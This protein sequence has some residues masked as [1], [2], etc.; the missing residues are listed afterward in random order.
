MRRGTRSC[1]RVLGWH[2]RPPCCGRSAFAVALSYAVRDEA[3]GVEY[4]EEVAQEC[5]DLERLARGIVCDG[6]CDY[7][8]RAFSRVR[9]VVGRLDGGVVADGATVE[10]V[11]SD[12]VGWDDAGH[13]NG[14]VRERLTFGDIGGSMPRP[15]KS[16]AS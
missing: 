15:W 5:L 1:R 7:V 12:F 16:M 8:H 10:V 9:C 4:R 14:D 13:L 6:A 3:V 11:D 2:R